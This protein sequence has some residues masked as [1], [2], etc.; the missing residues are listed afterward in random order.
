VPSS[1]SSL[2]TG[3]AAPSPSAVLA[4]G[5]SGLAT[6]E[7][8]LRYRAVLASGRSGLTTGD[9]APRRRVVLSNG[10]GGLATGAVLASSSSGLAARETAPRCCPLLAMRETA[11]CR[12]SSLDGGGN[13]RTTVETV[14]SQLGRPHSGL[15]T[16][17]ITRRP[18]VVTLVCPANANTH[19][20]I[21]PH[22]SLSSLFTQ[23]TPET[24]PM[25]PTLVDLGAARTRGKL[26]ALLRVPAAAIPRHLGLR[27]VQEG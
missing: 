11:L 24:S 14:A 8:V 3:D 16:G 21:S 5:D 13:D 10:D 6:G 1:V 12:C 15:V 4:N 19:P 27:E 22:L 7:T 17:D 23:H 18:C 26:A 2:A 25:P 9:T 20:H